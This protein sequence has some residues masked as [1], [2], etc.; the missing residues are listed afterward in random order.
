VKSRPLS[1]ERV[2][3]AEPSCAPLPTGAAD[4]VVRAAVGSLEGAS[5]RSA[6]TVG[7]AVGAGVVGVAVGVSVVGVSV[8]GVAVVGV[9]V[10]GVA[11]VLSP[12]C[13]VYGKQTDR[14]TH[15]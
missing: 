3:S 7:V 6:S 12:D 5:L 15:S 1:A 10:V 11:V 9:S 14:G 8:I 2:G 4:A 13:S